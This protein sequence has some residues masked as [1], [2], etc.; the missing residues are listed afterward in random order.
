[1]FA[2]KLGRGVTYE[3]TFFE[4]KAIEMH[5]FFLFAL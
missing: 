5:N 3:M 4:L 1:M 2:D